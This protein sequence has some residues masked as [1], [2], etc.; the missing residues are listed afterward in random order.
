MRYHRAATG[1]ISRR[2]DAGRPCKTAPRAV[3]LKVAGNRATELGN[4]NRSIRASLLR[5]AA[6]TDSGRAVRRNPGNE[7][8]ETTESRVHDMAVRMRGVGAPGRLGRRRVHTAAT[9]YSNVPARVGDRTDKP[10]PQQLRTATGEGNEMKARKVVLPPP[11]NGI[12]PAAIAITAE[13]IGVCRTLE[14][15][16][17]YLGGGTML[18]ADW[19]HRTS[20]DIDILIAPGLSMN[21]LPDAAARRIE[22][23]ID[24]THGETIRSP[25]Q[26]LSVRFPNRGKVDIF[27]SG[28][29]LPGLEEAIDIDGRPGRRL[30]DAQIFAGKFRRAVE[31]HVAA[32]DLFDM[33]YAAETWRTGL[34]QA[35]NTIPE[36]DLNRITTFWRSAEPKIREEA[37]TKLTGVNEQERIRPSQL[38]EKTIR[39]LEKHRYAEIRITAAKD[40]AVVQ[41]LTAGGR[42]DVYESARENIERDFVARG[43]TRHLAQHNIGARD[44][45]ERTRDKSRNASSDETVFHIRTANA[46]RARM[47]M[48]KGAELTRHAGKNVNPQERPDGQRRPQRAAERSQTLQRR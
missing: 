7:P 1:P 31:R 22:K 39:Q 45:I 30:S 24:Q 35:L 37:Q 28:R 13:L 6:F 27:S 33:C 3:V 36:T 25:D 12:W 46:T 48:Y 5:M 44:A 9:R 4:R 26:K 8:I 40:R 16:D 41:T 47:E 2:P 14:G 20:T 17:W 43:I 29:Q 21:A 34:T 42:A 11:A 32:R 10:V 38:V 18:A 15:D 23:L 19:Q